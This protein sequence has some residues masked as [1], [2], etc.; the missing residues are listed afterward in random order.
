MM[1]LRFI[2]VIVCISSLFLFIAYLLFSGQ[3]VSDSFC[4][5]MDLAHQASLSM[6]CSWQEYW[7][8]LPYPTPGDLPDPGIEPVSHA[9]SGR[10]FTTEP[11]GNLAV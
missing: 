9:L 8:R 2:H 3:V 1:L 10:I 6:G 7:S 11:P 5:P 4:N